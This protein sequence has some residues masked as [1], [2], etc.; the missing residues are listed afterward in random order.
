LSNYSHPDVRKL[1]V[2]R[3][4]AGRVAEDEVLLLKQNFVPGDAELI[5]SAFPITS[6]RFTLHSFMFDVL[7]TCEANLST[8]CTT[9]M[10]RVYDR[11]PCGNCRRRAVLNLLA[12]NCCPQWILDECAFDADEDV[13]AVLQAD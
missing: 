5:D 11:T 8:E 6:D 12:V 9:V 7:D 13:R 10:R 4:T 1:A 2:A 3:I